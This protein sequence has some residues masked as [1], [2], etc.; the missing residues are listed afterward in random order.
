MASYTRWARVPVDKMVA[1][2]RED[3]ELGKYVFGRYGV[4][5]GP[6]R[7]CSAHLEVCTC[8]KKV[9]RSKG[10]ATKKLR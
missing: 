3:A 10:C 6:V 2:A 5:D 8:N 7:R 1:V 4:E 9:R